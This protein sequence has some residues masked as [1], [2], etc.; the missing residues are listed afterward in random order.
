MIFTTLVSPD[1]VLTDSISHVTYTIPDPLSVMLYFFWMILSNPVF[2]TVLIS[3]LVIVFA[4]SLSESLHN[5]TRK[6]T[7]KA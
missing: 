5:L 1:S 6:L 4:P 3:Y 2:L 7:R